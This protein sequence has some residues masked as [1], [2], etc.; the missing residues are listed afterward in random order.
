MSTI[1][2]RGAILDAATTLIRDGATLSLDSVARAAGL[3]KPGLMYHYPTKRALMLGL[4]DHVLDGYE[5]ALAQRLPRGVDAPVE[6]RLLAYAEWALTAEVDS[7][8]L[9]MFMDPRLRE[10]LSA[11]WTER[12]QRWVGVPDGLPAERR[13]RLLSVRLIAD[14]SWFADASGV[15]PLAADERRRVLAV[16]RDL[17]GDL[18]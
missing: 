13:A 15:A 17:V 4:V 9:V 11:R 8:D 1:L 3:T 14:G 6:Q 18:R 2:S 10:Q 16:A 7:A 5:E 12:M